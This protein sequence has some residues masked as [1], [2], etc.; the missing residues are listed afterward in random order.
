MSEAIAITVIEICG[1]AVG[2]LS[3]GLCFGLGMWL[4][5]VRMIVA[6]VEKKEADQ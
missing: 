1:M 2:G 4:S 5:G 6:T 3:L